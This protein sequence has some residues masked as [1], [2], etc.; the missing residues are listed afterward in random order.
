MVVCLTKYSDDK[1]RILAS[2]KNAIDEL[3][4]PYIILSFLNFLAFTAL[5]VRRNLCDN[6][7]CV[8]FQEITHVLDI[9]ISRMY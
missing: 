3:L 4:T 5:V 2:K 7:F 6:L 8:I 1:D 9:L